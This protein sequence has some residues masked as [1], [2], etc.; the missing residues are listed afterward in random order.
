[1]YKS[2]LL[3]LIMLLGNTFTLSAQKYWDGSSSL[4]EREADA[5]ILCK[6]MQKV[7]QQNGVDLTPLYPNQSTFLADRESLDFEDFDQKYEWTK[8]LLRKA[9]SVMGDFDDEKCAK[10][11]DQKYDAI[12]SEEKDQV[13]DALQKH[14]IPLKIFG[15]LME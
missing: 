9:E 6:C 1:M 7:L 4:N 5:K 3:F 14:C 11:M 8:P 12:G 10:E 15:K 2:F 13:V